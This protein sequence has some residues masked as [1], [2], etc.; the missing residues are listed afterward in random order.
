MSNLSLHQLDLAESAVHHALI[1]CK[2]F[3]EYLY[4]WKSLGDKKKPP[5][6]RRRVIPIDKQSSSGMHF[7]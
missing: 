3:K 5:V 1:L 4:S 6:V 7:L 2:T